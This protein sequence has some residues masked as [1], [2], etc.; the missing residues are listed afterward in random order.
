L[1]RAELLTGI[2]KGRALDRE[3]EGRALTMKKELFKI[4]GKRMF[5]FRDK[6]YRYNGAR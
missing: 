6:K 3:R 4:N 1:L 5:S 2:V